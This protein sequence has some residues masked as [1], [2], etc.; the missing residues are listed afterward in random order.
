MEYCNYSLYSAAAT[1]LG[2]LSLFGPWSRGFPLLSGNRPSLVRLSPVLFFFL[3]PSSLLLFSPLLSSTLHSPITSIL[4]PY[5]K[6]TISIRSILFLHLSLHLLLHQSEQFSKM[7]LRD[8]FVFSALTLAACG[9]A[10]S[11][12]KTHLLI[13]NPPI[14]STIQDDNHVGELVSR[15]ANNRCGPEFGKC[16]D[17]KCCSTA[18]VSLNGFLSH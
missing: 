11:I 18:G 8:F 4:S 9:S 7:H 13:D 12:P 6:H 17:G 3:F 15:D 10:R 14:I 16:P 2:L 5:L 1:S